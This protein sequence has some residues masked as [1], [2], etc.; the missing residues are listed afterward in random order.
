MKTEH[1]PGPWKITRDKI[2]PCAIES[3]KYPDT[4]IAKVYLT[5]PESRKRTAEF[6]ANARLIARAPELLEALQKVVDRA[7]PLPP[8]STGQARIQLRAALIDEL[9]ELIT[10]TTGGQ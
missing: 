9:R 8:D 4:A 5:D 10:K 1:S 3:D 2:S 6:Q 7:A